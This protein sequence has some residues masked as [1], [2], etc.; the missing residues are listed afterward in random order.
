MQMQQS[1]F[2]RRRLKATLSRLPGPLAGVDEVGRGCIAGPVMAAAVVFSEARL[3][4]GLTDS[5]L[6]SEKQR[7]DLFPQITEAHYY[8]VGLATVEEID[9]INILQASFLAMRRALEALEARWGQSCGFVLVDGSLRIPKL[10]TQQAP[11]IKGDL[12]VPAIAA[13]SI[14]AKVSRDRLMK[15]FD[16][17]FPRFGFARHKGYGSEYHREVIRQ[18]GPCELHRKT[19]RGVKEYLEVGPPR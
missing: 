7:E 1:D 10:N 13:A 17:K 4:K 19:F 12:R 18:H 2:D 3:P 8:G 14:V 6:L 16:L 9:A 15:E 11:V 5:K